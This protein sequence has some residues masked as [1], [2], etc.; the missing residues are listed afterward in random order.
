MVV[1]S[2][3]GSLRG[4][5]FSFRKGVWRL[6]GEPLTVGS[7]PAQLDQDIWALAEHLLSRAAPQPDGQGESPPSLWEVVSGCSPLRLVAYGSSADR[8]RH[9]TEQAIRGTPCWL[10]DVLA[11][12]DGRQQGE[13]I[14]RLAQLQPDVLLILEGHP[15]SL[16]PILSAIAATGLAETTGVVYVG[17]SQ[18]ALPVTDALSHGCCAHFIL[19]AAQPDSR[20]VDSGLEAVRSTLALLW[21]QKTLGQSQGDDR[22]GKW[23]DRRTIIALKALSHAVAAYASADRPLLLARLDAESS[24]LISCRDRRMAVTS[25]PSGLGRNLLLMADRIQP[26]LDRWLG[27]GVPATTWFDLCLNRYGESGMAWDSHGPVVWDSAAARALLSLALAEHQAAHPKQLAP[28]EPQ[29]LRWW[30][31]LNPQMPI[32][33]QCAQVIGTGPIIA[34]LTAE[35]A[36]S[37]LVDGLQP[38]GIV[39]IYRD[40]SDLWPFL[41]ALE[42]SQPGSAGLLLDDSLELLTTAIRPFGLPAPGRR[43]L[44]V[45]ISGHKVNRLVVLS[46]DYLLIPSTESL[47]M[48]VQ[49]LPQAGVDIGAGAGVPLEQ[50]LSG[51][52]L[53]LIVDCRGRIEPLSRPKRQRQSVQGRGHSLL[54]S[55]G[56]REVGR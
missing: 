25:S 54:W 19:P 33:R 14:D 48:A 45:L 18:G 24:I 11:A 16:H 5:L 51:G 43:A 46:G 13:L 42:V 3:F 12:D 10:L 50:S 27:D 6:V 56:R 4:A 17:N 22:L 35:R 55:K 34:A 1:D 30:E 7:D 44:I 32:R 40:R 53:G 8:T 31:K 41:G 21:E 29:P 37:L 9:W 49:L 39:S 23:A 38:E 47:S 26:Y 2:C 28:M 20:S 15:A 52:K 36:A